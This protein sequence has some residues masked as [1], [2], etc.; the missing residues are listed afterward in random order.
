VADDLTAPAPS[1]PAT[2][3]LRVFISYRR[4]DSAAYARQVYDRL[5]NE[6]G[7]EHIF[8]DIDKLEPG[9]DFVERIDEAVGSTDVLIAIM[10]N[11]WSTAK[12]RGKRR[13]DNPEDFV[14]LEVGAGL[15][16]SDVRVIPVLVHGAEMPRVEKLPKELAQLVR[17]NALRL[18]DER[19]DHDLDRLVRALRGVDKARRT[20][21]NR[22]AADDEAAAEHGIGLQAEAASSPPAEADF[23]LAK[24]LVNRQ[25]LF[26]ARA[27]YQRAIDS[28][29]PEWA[30]RATLALADL[31]WIHEDDEAGGRAIYQRMIDS[32]DPEW[33][34]RATLALGHVLE[35]KYDDASVVDRS[36]GAVDSL[37]RLLAGVRDAYQTA[38]DS[39]HAEVA[40]EA[41]YHLGYLLEVEVKDLVHARAAYQR[42]IDSGHPSWGP[43]AAM[44]LA[45]LLQWDDEAG[46]RTLWQGVIDSGHPAAPEANLNLGILLEDQ[47][48]M[49]GARAAYQRAID[50]G[51]PDATPE[52]AT[53]LGRLLEEQGDMAGAQAAYRAGQEVSRSRGRRSTARWR[54]TDS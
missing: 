29:H 33:A 49:E 7:R 47:G 32:E 23:T 30:P 3:P 2:A 41:A 39:G 21:I 6:F 13:L 42:A 27:A 34:P 54:L 35:S 12:D 52:A 36:P 48:D 51:D 45:Q 40:P 24:E 19:W 16:H 28:G 46:R 25:E 37:G 43:S 38:A 14:R 31:L 8:F 1:G 53:T 22:A 26:G 20:P 18:D 50:S 9:V 4:E 17:R 11:S 44:K 10:G 5:S 15:R